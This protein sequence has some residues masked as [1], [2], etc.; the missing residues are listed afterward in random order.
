[1]FLMLPGLSLWGKHR[2]LST[3]LLSCSDGSCTRD[4]V[5]A[6]FIPNKTCHHFCVKTDKHVNQGEMFY[7][8]ACKTCLMIPV[9]VSQKANSLSAIQSGIWQALS[10]WA[11]DSTLYSQS[12][13][14]GSPVIGCKWP[15]VV[16]LYLFSFSLPLLFSSFLLFFAAPWLVS[17]KKSALCK[18]SLI[19]DTSDPFD[20]GLWGTSGSNHHKVT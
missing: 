6:P 17:L 11:H 5:L 2:T 15:K 9:P 7:I 3:I 12:L 4:V 14:V 20:A 18:F 1:M 13:C 16:H 19:C 10:F 8:F